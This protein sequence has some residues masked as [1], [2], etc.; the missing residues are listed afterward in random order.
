MQIA[1]ETLLRS[2][3][4][5]LSPSVQLE[6]RMG[7]LCALG[8]SSAAPSPSP[9][10]LRSPAHAVGRI[11]SQLFCGNVPSVCGSAAVRRAA[12]PHTLGALPRARGMCALRCAYRAHGARTGSEANAAPQARIVWHQAMAM[13]IGAGV[14]PAARAG[15]SRSTTGSSR[16]GPLKYMLH[17]PEK[18]GSNRR[19][20]RPF[21]QYRRFFTHF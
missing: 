8:S 21:S 6:T 17:C 11:Q 3:A 18:R 13:A 15:S 19:Q 9:A 5:P 10:L 16:A 2:S 7:L 14:S 4:C 12:V 1:V 20:I